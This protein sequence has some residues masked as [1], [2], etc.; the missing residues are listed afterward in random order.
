MFSTYPHAYDDDEIHTQGDD[1]RRPRAGR[2]A[3]PSI[4]WRT[5]LAVC[6]AQQV[7]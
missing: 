4:A 7:R 3:A 2:P 6:R 1:R 5:P